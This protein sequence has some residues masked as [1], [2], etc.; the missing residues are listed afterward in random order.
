[1]LRLGRRALAI[2]SNNR[3]YSS[4]SDGADLSPAIQ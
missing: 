4:S 2:S 3:F 1:V